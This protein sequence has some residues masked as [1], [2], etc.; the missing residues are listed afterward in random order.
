MLASQVKKHAIIVII[1][2][3][4]R[5]RARRVWNFDFADERNFS[6][7]RHEMRYFVVLCV[8]PDRSDEDVVQCVRASDVCSGT[9]SCC[10]D[11][12]RAIHCPIGVFCNTVG[13]IFS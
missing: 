10:A 11:R 12:L 6:S 8:S 13:V 5:L 3:V 4:Y 1:H 2:S 9:I 7:Q